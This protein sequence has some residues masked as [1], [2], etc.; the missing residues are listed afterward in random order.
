L[1]ALAEN[2]LEVDAAGL[3]QASGPAAA[4]TAVSEE[5]SVGKAISGGFIAYGGTYLPIPKGYTAGSRFA[6]DDQSIEVVDIYPGNMTFAAAQKDSYLTNG[7]LIHLEIVPDAYTTRQELLQ[8]AKEVDAIMKRQGWRHTS[9]W[10][11]NSKIPT[12]MIEVKE[13]KHVRIFRFTSKTTY[14]FLAAEWTPGLQSIMTGL[15]E[16]EPAK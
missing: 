1:H 14:K 13:P 3:P 8:F 5:T 6:P 2:I 10:L 11:K 4:K 7:S 12:L 15:K 9:R 16:A